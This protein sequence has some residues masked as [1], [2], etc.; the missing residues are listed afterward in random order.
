MKSLMNLVDLIDFNFGFRVIPY[1]F[2]AYGN[3]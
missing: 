1:R 3:F 2:M